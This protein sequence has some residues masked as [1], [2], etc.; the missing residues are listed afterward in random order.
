MPEPG[1]EPL[2][3][4]A[5]AIAMDAAQAQFLRMPSS[6]CW[7]YAN[8]IIKALRDA[9]R[10]LSDNADPATE[11]LSDSDTPRPTGQVR[12]LPGR[13]GAVDPAAAIGPL[14]DSV[15]C[16]CGHLPADHH[17][18]HGQCRCGTCTRWRPAIGPLSESRW[19]RWWRD[20]LRALAGR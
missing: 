12:G 16:R 4:S 7:D 8:A 15:T 20:L 5:E 19:R 11:P 3:I 14:F 17:G 13:A 1:M 18:G 6:N 10:L 9:G 2:F